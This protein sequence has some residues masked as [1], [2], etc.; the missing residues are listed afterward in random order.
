V[1]GIL[2]NFAGNTPKLRALSLGE[3]G[4][5]TVGCPDTPDNPAKGPICE[6]PNERRA[7]V[8]AT[9]RSPRPVHRPQVHRPS[10][11]GDPDRRI[12]PGHGA[13]GPETGASAQPTLRLSS[14]G[15]AVRKLQ[16]LLNEVSG[17]GLNPDGDFGT[18][19]QK[20]VMAFRHSQGLPSDGIVSPKTWARL[21][22]AP[23]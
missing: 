7:D 3:L 19:T 11:R 12:E 15:E 1:E 20:A 22:S 21:L 4:A 6:D 8:N 10:R 5:Q 2:R 9:T 16:S 13:G 17:S 14:K 23:V 18:W